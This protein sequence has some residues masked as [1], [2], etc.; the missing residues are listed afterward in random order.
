MAKLVLTNAQVIINAVDLSDHV[1]T[2][3]VHYTA[4]EVD[5]TSMGQAGISRLPGLKDWSMDV[6]FANDFALASVDATLF[7]L[8]GAPAFA[9]EVRPVKA[10]RS[11]TNPAYTGNAILPTYSPLGQKV[12][13]FNTAPIKLSG[14]DGVA[15][16]RLTA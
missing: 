15:L 13:A 12:G 16:Q 9:V 1:D 8:V 2:V 11:T 10:A 4:A 14:A 3:A 5:S 7:P 6:T